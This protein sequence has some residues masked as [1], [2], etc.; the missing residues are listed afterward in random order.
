MVTDV[1]IFIVYQIASRLGAPNTLRY[2]YHRRSNEP[3]DPKILSFHNQSTSCPKNSTVNT[4]KAIST[5]TDESVSQGA[6]PFS[7][8][9]TVEVMK[10][11][12]PRYAAWGYSSSEVYSSYDQLSTEEISVY[13]SYGNFTPGTIPLSAPAESLCSFC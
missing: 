3:N 2:T 12:A 5:S 8:R 11:K 13:R 10:R 6:A 7:F 1:S 4:T 9:R